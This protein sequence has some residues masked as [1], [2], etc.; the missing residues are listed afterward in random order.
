MSDLICA[1][2]LPEDKEIYT[3]QTGQPREVY[4]SPQEPLQDHR[5]IQNLLIFK[6]L[7]TGI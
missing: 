7:K 5:L 4:T 1:Q 6:A 2:A 3:G